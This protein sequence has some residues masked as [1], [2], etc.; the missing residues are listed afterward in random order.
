MRHP[1]VAAAYRHVS[2]VEL[3]ECY[4]LLLAV[5]Y[6]CPHLD[7]VDVVVRAVADGDVERVDAVFELHLQHLGV[8]LSHLLEA[9]NA[10]VER[11][12]AVGVLDGE[13]SLS[14][15]AQSVHGI[16]VLAEGACRL[17]L[18]HVG[19]VE[20]VAVIE[21]LQGLAFCDVEGE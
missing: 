5:L 1:D 11:E 15:S 2:R 17:Q 16:G 18:C 19:G 6:L 4:G 10:H 20:A 3:L 12:V 14:L 7:D 21:K 13:G 8:S 9:F